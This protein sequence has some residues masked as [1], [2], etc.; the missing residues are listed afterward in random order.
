MGWNHDNDKEGDSNWDSGKGE[1]K[2]WSG[3]QNFF[4]GITKNVK[5]I[6]PLLVFWCLAFAIICW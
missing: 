3:V 2:N 5:W 1:K 4:G 6:T